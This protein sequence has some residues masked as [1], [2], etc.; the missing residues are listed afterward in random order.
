[1]A[2]FT[3]IY[4]RN[5]ELSS[6]KSLFDS[7]KIKDISIND[8]LETK[9]P[10][11]EIKNRDA[12]FTAYTEQQKKDL[13]LNSSSDIKEDTPIYPPAVLWVQ[14]DKT[15]LDLI[16]SESKFIKKEDFDSFLSMAQKNLVEN[17]DYVKSQAIKSYPECTLWIWSKSIERKLTSNNSIYG[18]ILNLTDYIQDL[19]TNVT[20]TGG[21]FQITIPFVPMVGNVGQIGENVIAGQRSIPGGW[22]I[23]KTNENKIIKEDGTVERVYNEE[24]HTSGVLGVNKVAL[25]ND[26][27]YSLDNLFYSVDN[28]L[29]KIDIGTAGLSVN[30]IVFIKFERL[31]L[32]HN[33][34]INDLYVD[35]SALNNEVFDMIGLID[36][37]T[38]NTNNTN[39]ISI[40]ITGRDCMKLILDDGSFFFPNSYADP[41][42]K[43]GIFKNIDEN[44]GDKM[45]TFNNLKRTENGSAGRF[46]VTG[47]IMPMFLP[48]ART[49][50]NV[51][52]LLI[53]TLANIEICPDEIFE[54]YGDKRTKFRKEKVKQ[55]KQKN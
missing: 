30:D 19:R 25:K 54:P 7:E 45:N 15:T 1:M 3:K 27:P 13:N 46:I 5:A 48:T 40:T 34:Y 10:N 2:K 36:S 21:N 14:K 29:R 53:K 41:N 44:R 52:D 16:T 17:R 43:G 31:A 35:P 9:D 23:D 33:Q 8:F 26:S 4:Y 18:V 50:E 37:V 11:T 12:L 39:D 42:A 49:I 22:S 20:E 47:M 6:I 38:T 51:V 55:K 28:S 24:I 32:E